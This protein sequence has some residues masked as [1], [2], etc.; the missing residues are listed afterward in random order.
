MKKSENKK[1][2]ILLGVVLVLLLAERIATLF[3]LGMQYTGSGDVFSYTMSAKRLLATGQL[4]YSTTYPTALIMPGI[5]SLIAGFM[6]VFGQDGGYAWSIAMRVFYY[7]LSVL[8]AWYTYRA[9]NVFAP[10][11]YGIIA[12]T[13]YFAP[14]LAWMCNVLSTEV[15]YIFCFTAALFYLFKM[16]ESPDAKYLT[17]FIIF[18]VIALFFRANAVVLMISMPFYLLLARN[19]SFSS[20]IKRTGILLVAVLCFILPWSLRNYRLFNDFIPLTYGADNP[21][22]QG[23][24]QCEG[25]PPDR[26]LDYTGN[27]D[28]IV[29]K[30]Y[31]DYFG[32][33]G[34]ALP[35]FAEYIEHISCGVK[36]RYRL[37]EW[38]KRDLGGLLKAYLIVKPRWMLN[39]S[40]YWDSVFDLP[41]SMMHWISIFNMLICAAGLLAS[42]VKKKLTLPMLFL[43]VLYIINIYSCAIS[44]VSDR[45]SSLFMTMRYIMAGIGIYII[46]SGF[47]RERKIEG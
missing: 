25:N 9:V 18:S 1:C 13:A 10:K 26:E 45:Y 39:W 15:P 32:N 38:V 29:K 33:N 17:G 41:Y 35:Q 2:E 42:L 47:R 37:S 30:D 43:T 5:S 28:E 36:A 7:V 34:E 46:F 31:S 6:Y 14:N 40:W 11:V 27:V 4:T 8:T 21:L 19:Y 44:F 3:D 24:Y 23:T 16:G 20:A 12:A 22:C